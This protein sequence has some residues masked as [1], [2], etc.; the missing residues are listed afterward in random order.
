MVSCLASRT[1]G[2][3]DSNKIDYQ[4]TLNCLEEGYATGSRHFILLSA[5]CVEKP[6]LEFQRAKLRFEAKLQELAEKD[7]SFSYS[8]VRPTAFFKSLAGQVKR[9]KDGSAYIMF[10]DGELSKCNAISERDL[11]D[12]IANCASDPSKRNQILPVGGP[13]KPVTP[14][15]QAEI[16]FRLLDKEPKFSKAPIGVMDVGISV[17][18]F[19]SKLLPGVKDAAE[20]ARIGKYYA[21]E[22]M[23]GPEYGSDTL[24]DFFTDVIENGLEGQE[25]GSAAVFSD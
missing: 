18:D 15:E 20:F 7:E 3:E 22:D 14:K 2:I 21:V 24:E 19:V 1:G 10:G 17:L 11:A 8:I 12:F 9:V 13:G 16:L 5:I 25:L 6:L 23:V 4:A